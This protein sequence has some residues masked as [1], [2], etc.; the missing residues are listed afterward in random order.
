MGNLARYYILDTLVIFFRRYVVSKDVLLI[1]LDA[2]GD[3]VIWLDSA[4]EF[5]RLY[6]DKKITL[7]AN[8]AW[9]DLATGLP[10]WDEVWPVDV[11]RLTNK[12][13]Y[14][15]KVLREI[16][17]AGFEIVIQPTFSRVFLHGD[18]MIRVSGATQRIGSEGD[19]VSINP[20]LKLI[21]DRWYTTLVPAMR[22]SLM[23]LERNAEFIRNL[24]G[25]D[26]QANQPVLQKFTQLPERLKISTPY[27]I[28][29]PGASWHG[30]QWSSSHFVEVVMQVHQRYGWLAVLCGGLSETRLCQII[31]DQS[32]VPAINLGGA[33]SLRELVELLRG[34]CILISNE[35][36]AVHLAAAVSTPAV[37]ILGGG[38]FGRFMPYPDSMS[39]TQPAVAMHKMACYNCNWICTQVHDPAGAVPCVSGVTVADVLT[40]VDAEIS[41]IDNYDI[42]VLKDDANSPMDAI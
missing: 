34:A 3:F 5:R 31:V 25:L 30:R 33:T 42:K 14:R 21:S 20:R 24:S 8:S 37:C 10:Y 13:I 16:R 29:F 41:K 1:R 18:A 38:H 35:T 26:F 11:K 7:C 19:P 28:V 9:I 36:S 32:A 2:I 39:D 23:E 40:L 4:K 17:K 22:S 27:F 6:P 15:F 12:S